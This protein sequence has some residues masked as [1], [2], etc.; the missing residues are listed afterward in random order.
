M[1]K[2]NKEL[3]MYLIFGCLTTIINIV[4][5]YVLY[6]IFNILNVASTAIAWTISVIFAFITNKI[7]VFES[8]SF[9]KNIILKELG[10]FL[11]YRIFSGVLDIVIMHTTVDILKLDSTICKLATNVIVIIINYILSKFHVFRK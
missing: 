11:I 9:D 4:S 3:I 2:P 10:L 5:Y 8:N 1:D 6:N 7:Y